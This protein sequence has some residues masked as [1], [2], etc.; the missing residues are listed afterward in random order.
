MR[1]IVM[2]AMGLIMAM[3]TAN[4][5][6]LKTGEV[7]NSD[8]GVVSAVET[9]SGRAALE[10]EGVL[11]ASGVV[12][13]NLGEET[14]S[15]EISD[16]QGKSRA[17][18]EIVITAAAVE[19]GIYTLPEGV[20]VADIQAIEAHIADIDIP[21]EYLAQIGEVLERGLQ[22]ELNAALDELATTGFDINTYEYGSGCASCDALADSYGFE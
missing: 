8:L 1:T 18:Q 13:L 22:D 2:A 11:V 17:A 14:V 7:Y 21:D 5:L 16:L 10:K 3:T 20:E 19:Q 15:V 4:A 9:P 6:T 12:F